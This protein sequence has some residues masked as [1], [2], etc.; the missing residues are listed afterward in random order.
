ME[1]IKCKFNLQ[2]T[3]YKVDNKNSQNF[4]NFGFSLERET[5]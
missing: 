5:S 1:Y 3:K 2:Y 4:Q